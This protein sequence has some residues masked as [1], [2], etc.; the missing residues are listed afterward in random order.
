MDHWKS[1]SVLIQ[2]TPRKDHNGS[3]TFNFVSVINNIIFKENMSKYIYIMSLWELKY[4][5]IKNH[6]T[7]IFFLLSL[8][9]MSSS[10]MN[11]KL[12]L[13]TPR[14][15]IEQFIS[16]DGLYL[17]ISGWKIFF[18]RHSYMSNVS[19]S[20]TRDLW[21]LNRNRHDYFWIWSAIN[22]IHLCR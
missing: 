9:L 20:R 13:V 10:I 18:S 8:N 12:F 2:F 11:Y 1:E 16:W 22:K 7:P 4:L 14:L 15:C 19:K 21:I 6:Y 3:A 17:F 5:Y